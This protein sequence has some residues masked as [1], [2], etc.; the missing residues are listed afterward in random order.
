M[1]SLFDETIIKISI[2]EYWHDV[3]RLVK[4]ITSKRKLRLFEC[5]FILEIK[6]C[7][8]CNSVV[9]GKTII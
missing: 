1:P 8:V 7:N 3:E 4:Q 9:W 5:V 6:Y 2:K